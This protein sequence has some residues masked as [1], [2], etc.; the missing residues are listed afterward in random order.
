MRSESNRYCLTYLSYLSSYPTYSIS[1]M[2]PAHTFLTEP[3][4]GKC[5]QENPFRNVRIDDDDKGEAIEKEEEEKE[6]QE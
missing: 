6:I 3:V 5:Y 2:S 4:L 1:K